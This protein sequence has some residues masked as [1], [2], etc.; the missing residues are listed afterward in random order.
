MSISGKTIALTTWTF[1]VK[2]MSLLFNML[3]SYNLFSCIIYDFPL[4]LYPSAN[5]IK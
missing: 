2:V 4:S 3:S 1:V 5:E